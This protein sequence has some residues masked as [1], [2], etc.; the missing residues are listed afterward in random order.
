MPSPIRFTRMRHERGSSNWHT[1]DECC[2]SWKSWFLMQ[3]CEATLRQC[4]LNC[5]RQSTNGPDS[6]YTCKGSM[7]RN[8]EL[9]NKVGGWF[10]KFRYSALFDYSIYD[11]K[12]HQRHRTPSIRIKRP[13]TNVILSKWPDRISMVA[14]HMDSS[15]PSTIASKAKCFRYVILWTGEKCCVDYSKYN[16]N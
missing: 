2:I 8:T 11:V 13:H 12:G 16:Y 3:N 9:H 6:E 14:K 7:E 5:I 15:R 1:N 4:Q 10:A